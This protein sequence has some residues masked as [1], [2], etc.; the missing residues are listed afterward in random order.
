[1]RFILLLVLIMFLNFGFSQTITVRK[2]YSDTATAKLEQSF[3]IKTKCFPIGNDLDEIDSVSSDSIPII[4]KVSDS[5]Y[6]V[7]RFNLQRLYSF[8]AYTDLTPPLEKYNSDVFYVTNKSYSYKKN[9]LIKTNNHL[10]NDKS[11]YYV[12]TTLL[13]NIK[14]GKIIPLKNSG[15]KID[16]ASI[17]LD[18]RFTSYSK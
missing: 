4:L 10:E 12:S 1:M 14:T 9:K 11:V 7:F 17:P 8:Y 6:V 13:K 3:T 18:V 2:N 16:K 15:I 5:N